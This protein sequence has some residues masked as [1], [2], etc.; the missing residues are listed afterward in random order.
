MKVLD[1]LRGH[2]VT[3]IEILILL[4]LIPLTDHC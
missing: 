1:I 2:G 3:V 4:T